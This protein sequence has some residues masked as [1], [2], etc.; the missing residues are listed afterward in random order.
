MSVDGYFGLGI[1][2]SDSSL[3]PFRY[4]VIVRASEIVKTFSRKAKWM[5]FLAD[6][7]YLYSVVDD[8]RLLD[9]TT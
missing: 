9:A 1:Q 7:V 4:R 3:L 6:S 2:A 5:R 8:C